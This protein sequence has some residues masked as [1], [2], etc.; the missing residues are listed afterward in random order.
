MFVPQ[1]V[2]DVL[3]LDKIARNMKRRRFEDGALRLD[4]VKLAFSLDDDGNPKVCHIYGT[5]NVPPPG[6][7]CRDMPL[8]LCTAKHEALQRAVALS[9]PRPQC[10]AMACATLFLAT[11]SCET[12]DFHPT[13]FAAFLPRQPCILETRLPWLP[14]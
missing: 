9:I 10:P 3:S 14:T 1:V 12:H 4:T 2:E 6:T 7:S 13:S 8:P 5:Q 11:S